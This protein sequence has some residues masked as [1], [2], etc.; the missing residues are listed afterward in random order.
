MRHLKLQ[1][2]LAS[3]LSLFTPHSALAE[4]LMDC[5]VQVKTLICSV[6]LE[7]FILTTASLMTNG[8]ENQ[9]DIRFELIDNNQDIIKT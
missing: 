8:W 4:D 7:D 5:T 2:A 9:I 6:T 3:S 1:L